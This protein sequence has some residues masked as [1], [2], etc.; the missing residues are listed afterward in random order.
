MTPSGT[1]LARTAPT[2]SGG[3]SWAGLASDDRAYRRANSLYEPE[4]EK[5][6]RFL[7]VQPVLGLVP[8]RGVRSVDDLVGDLLATMGRQTMQDDH[9]RRRE[10]DELVVDLVGGED[11]RPFRRF[12][13]SPHA[14]P[15]VGVQN[16]RTVDGDVR[17]VRRLDGG[18]GL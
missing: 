9:V 2:R 10:V 8:H 1:R 16:V 4:Q 5:Q 14:R 11:Q 3:T 17:V 12:V 13:V 15:D 6:Q 18:P 7:R